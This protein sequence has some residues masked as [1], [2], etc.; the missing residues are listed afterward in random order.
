MIENIETVMEGMSEREKKVTLALMSAIERAAIVRW[1]D[2]DVEALERFTTLTREIGQE[3][4]GNGGVV[5]AL[6]F[7]DAGENQ[8][9]PEQIDRVKKVVDHLLTEGYS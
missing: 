5:N 2:R 8:L 7:E 9:E 4:I 6:K 3:Q 1:F